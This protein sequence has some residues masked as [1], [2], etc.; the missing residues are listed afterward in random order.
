MARWAAQVKFSINPVL[1][2]I[3]RPKSLGGEP[4][5]LTSA[6]WLVIDETREGVFLLRFGKNGDFAGDTIDR[7]PMDERMTVCNMSI[8]GGARAGY[9]NPDETTFAYLKGRKFAPTGAAW[10]KAVA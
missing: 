1:N 8:E 3:G 5:S 6:A 10:D 9:I 2:Y 4:A 7:M